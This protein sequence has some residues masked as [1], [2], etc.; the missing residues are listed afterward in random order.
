MNT[1]EPQPLQSSVYYSASMAAMSSLIFGMSLTVIG[2]MRPHVLDLWEKTMNKEDSANRWGTASGNIFLGCLVSNILVNILKPNMKRTLMLNGILYAAGY[3]VLLSSQTFAAIYSGRLIMGL[4]SG[5]TC[6]IVSVYTSFIS[7]PERRGLLLSFHPLG[8]ITGITLGNILACLNT[9]A[10]WKIPLFTALAMIAL[11]IAGMAGI[12]DVCHEDQSS[13]TSLLG[14]LGKRKAR[15]SIF[16]AAAV[17]VAQHL[18]GVDYI[19]L[20]LKDLFPADV[21]SP[22]AM[23]IGVSSFAILINVLFAK[24]VDLIGRKP[25]IIASS[26]IAGAATTMLA[27]G[28]YP[29]AAALLFMFGYNVGLSSI[30]WFITTEIFPL[31]YA[32]PAALLGISLNWLSAYGVITLLYPMHTKHGDSMFLFYTACMAV[33]VCLMALLFRETKNK[34]PGF[35]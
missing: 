19:T 24:Y 7:P 28:L 25:L 5:V 27:F 22:E 16:L 14:L 32:N 1:R 3:A 17:H 6:A 18:C 2:C 4:A 33:F 29:P 30:P 13:E 8:I 34:T 15:K 23:A 21:Y 12:V 9:D 10:T 11:S 20:F 35:Q 26:L 31:R